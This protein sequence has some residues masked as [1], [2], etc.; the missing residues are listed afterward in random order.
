M[1]LVLDPDERTPLKSNI[2]KKNPIRNVS[3]R[4]KITRVITIFTIITTIKFF[5]TNFH[6]FSHLN[7]FDNTTD[8]RGYRRYNDIL[9]FGSKSED[10]K[11]EK[12]K[13]AR[14]H[15]HDEKGHHRASKKEAK[16]G[17]QKT[18][19]SSPKHRTS[20]TKN[21]PDETIYNDSPF[22]FSS[23]PSAVTSTYGNSSNSS[24]DAM[25]VTNG[26]KSSTTSE[27]NSTMSDSS[28]SNSSSEDSTDTS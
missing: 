20:N 26:D 27:V 18:N 24:N 2:S 14:N 3:H 8:L 21:D 15:N 12:K 10:K 9:F 4:T 23:S 13:H 17:H 28:H 7:S 19:N 1:A 22:N 11:F 6:G 16:K 5:V 25:I